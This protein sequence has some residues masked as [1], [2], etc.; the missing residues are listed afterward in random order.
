[1]TATQRFKHICACAVSDGIPR[2]SILVALVVGTVLNII[3]QGDALITRASIDWYKIIL[4]YLVPYG[5][6]T[7]GAVSLQ[8]P[9]ILIDGRKDHAIVVAAGA[10]DEKRTENG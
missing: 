7:Y 5:V 3:N 8:L 1:M 9:H 4:T 6:C 10:E 2:R